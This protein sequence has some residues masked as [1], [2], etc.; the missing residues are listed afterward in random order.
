MNNK[1]LDK[2]AKK[3]LFSNMLFRSGKLITSI[4]LNIFLWKNTHDIKI[5]ALFNIVFHLFYS[6]TY[7]FFA[8]IAKN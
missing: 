1:K 2:K 8:R 5:I 6:I 4:F 7:T 3:L